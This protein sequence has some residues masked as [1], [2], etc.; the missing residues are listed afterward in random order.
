M[1]CTLSSA[2]VYVLGGGGG[3]LILKIQILYLKGG[4]VYKFNRPEKQ[5]RKTDRKGKEK[6][7]R[8]PVLGTENDGLKSL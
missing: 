6:A 1:Y 4:V 2:Q 8:C 3:Y 7:N 5:T